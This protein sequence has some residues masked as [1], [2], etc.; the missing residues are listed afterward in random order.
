MESQ[1]HPSEFASPALRALSEQAAR[2][3]QEVAAPKAAQ[4]DAERLWPEHSMRALG[5]AG[6]LG[7]HVPKRLGGLGQG[8]LGLIAVTE[9][10]GQACSSSSM[11]FGMHCVGTAV[12]AAKST[13]EHESAFLK[14]IARGEHITTL[15]LSESGSG[16]HFYLPETTLDRVDGGFSI[17]GV[18]QWVTNA[19]HADSYVVSCRGADDDAHNGEFTCVVVDA[20][21][22]G[23]ELLKAWDGFGMR[24]NASRPVRFDNVRVSPEGLL[25][26]EGDQIW[27]V[28]EVVAPYFLTAMAGTYLGIAQAAFDIACQRVQS[29]HYEPIGDSLADAPVVQYKVAELW[30]K[31]ESARQMIYRAAR[32]GDA[33][34][35]NALSS[36]LMS[37][38]IAGDAAVDICNEAMSLCGGSGYG[39]NGT[40]PRLLRDARAS[41]VMAPTTNVLKLWAGRSLLGLP[42]L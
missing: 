8:L 26:N 30:A 38:A 7:L 21:A 1:T 42:I 34:D 40:L 16:V 36:I 31:L 32:L 28:F 33:G 6:L 24:G 23:C 27:Y 3:A 19:G 4:V 14:P 10:L 35:P 41:H 25:G 13:S 15:A 20:K 29:R 18:K 9:Q 2:I 5:D 17:D 37:K 12:I 39:E 11:S 22:H